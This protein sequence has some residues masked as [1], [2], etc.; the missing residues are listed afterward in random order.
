MEEA[1]HPPCVGESAPMPSEDQAVE[2]PRSTAVLLGPNRRTDRSTASPWVERMRVVEDPA[3][4]LERRRVYFG[5]TAPPGHGT[6]EET[7]GP[8][9]KSDRE[10]DPLVAAT[11]RCG[12]TVQNHPQARWA[13][14]TF[15][16]S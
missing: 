7:A 12:L 10:P 16:G 6:N 15:P 2:M 8:R 14:L 9:E 4:N 1:L 5:T 3:L 11:L 13:A